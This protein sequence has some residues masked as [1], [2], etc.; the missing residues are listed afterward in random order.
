VD[1][2]EVIHVLP[3]LVAVVHDLPPPLRE[4]FPHMSARR[5]IDVRPK[6]ELPSISTRPDSMLCAVVSAS[7]IR[8]IFFAQRRCHFLRKLCVD[9][10]RPLQP[11]RDPGDEDVLLRR[12]AG[13]GAY[14]K[15][16]SSSV[17]T[18]R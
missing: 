17:R 1:A 9:I 11:R 7:L 13:P 5:G 12:E 14:L 6:G 2:I 16:A 4:R 8:S 18:S 10:R 3:E 15:P